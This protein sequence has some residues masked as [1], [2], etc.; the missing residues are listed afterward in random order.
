MTETLLYLCTTSTMGDCTF[1]FKLDLNP[2]CSSAS[3]LCQCSLNKLLIN[4][5]SFSF[6]SLEEYKSRIAGQV[7]AS[8]FYAG[9]LL[10]A[11]SL[12]PSTRTMVSSGQLPVLQISKIP[13]LAH[14]VICRMLCLPLVFVKLFIFVAQLMLCCKAGGLGVPAIRA[15]VLAKM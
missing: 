1:L 9:Q 5:K 15:T 4:F 2:K 14:L 10:P 11:P 8:S 6:A 13:G 3:L 12:F 7:I